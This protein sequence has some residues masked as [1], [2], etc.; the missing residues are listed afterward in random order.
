M[1]TLDV[2]AMAHEVRATLTDA[3]NAADRSL[4]LFELHLKNFKAG[5]IPADVFYEQ[6]RGMVALADFDIR[7]GLEGFKALH[8][9]M[10]AAGWQMALEDK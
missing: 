10:L 9:R 7:D 4:N 8:D 1:T 5:K 2:D 6:A 3:R